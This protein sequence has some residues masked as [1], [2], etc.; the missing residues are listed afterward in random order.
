[1]T[2][3]TDELMQLLKTLESISA[4]LKDALEE[5]K[6]VLES[7]DSQQ[8]IRISTVKKGLIVNLERHTKTTHLFLKNKGVSKGLYGLNE[9]IKKSDQNN[10][11]KQL[12]EVWLNIQ[13]LSDDNK[14]SNDIN[15]SII[16]L[17][18]RYTQRSLDV[19]RGQVGVGHATYGADGQSLKSK[20]SRNLSIA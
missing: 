17:N 11:Q 1:M 10:A 5:E 18:R 12:S 14:L 19:L 7:L 13:A 20:V 6:G 3:S 15:G 4:Q 9:L 16:E 2:H 8:L